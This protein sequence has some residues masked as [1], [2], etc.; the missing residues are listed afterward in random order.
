MRWKFSKL[1]K[2]E[3]V[4]ERNFATAVATGDGAGSHDLLKKVDQNLKRGMDLCTRENKLWNPREI[5]FQQKQYD[6]FITRYNR[7]V[8]VKQGNPL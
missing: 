3:F 5:R 8:N 6:N 2:Q 4:G 1:N 7:A